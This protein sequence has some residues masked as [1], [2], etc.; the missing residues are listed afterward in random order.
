M[1][2]KTPSTRKVRSAPK[3]PTVMARVQQARAEANAVAACLIVASTIKEASPEDI[4]YASHNS[5]FLQ[6]QKIAIYLTVVE[7]R[8]TPRMV[9]HAFGCSV[10]KIKFA[11]EAVLTL[12]DD[13]DWDAKIERMGDQIC[14]YE[15]GRP[16]TLN[17]GS[18]Q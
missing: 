9:A 11:R 4:L 1:A 12:R 13:P 5:P 6:A 18:S 8:N 2:R 15:G 14:P 16:R 3:V 10:A 7:M 17:V